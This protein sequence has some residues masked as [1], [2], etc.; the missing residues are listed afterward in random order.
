M[1]R[2]AVTEPHPSASKAGYFSSGVGGAGN[3]RRYKPEEV[4][5]G[6]DATGPASRVP[7][8]KPTKRVVMGGR[9]GAGNYVSSRH[10]ESIFQFDEEMVNN[11]DVS[12]PVYK[13]GR[14][15]QGNIFASQKP[16]S[17]RKDSSDSSGSE[18]DRL[19]LSA[20]RRHSGGV[21][22]MFGR[23]SS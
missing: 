15:G 23:R 16:A 6:P 5:K 2:L 8:S 14:G 1:S 22:S 12:A 18:S 3:F 4:S 11:R 9:G 10:E 17:S 19:S 13:I 21:F 20:L 7:L